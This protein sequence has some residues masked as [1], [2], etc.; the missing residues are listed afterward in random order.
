MH[1]LW[2]LMALHFHFS[3]SYAFLFT[4][5]F[6]RFLFFLVSFCYL[7]VHSPLQYFSFFP[8]FL[9]YNF[10]ISLFNLFLQYSLTSLP[11]VGLFFISV[12]FQNLYFIHVFNIYF[13]T[14]YFLSKLSTYPVSKLSLLEHKAPNCFPYVSLQPSMTLFFAINFN[15][16][17]VMFNDFFY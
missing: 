12:I 6:S 4:L 15:T 8:S 1:F 10:V 16:S 13:K 9:S 2:M 3:L 7:I 14:L 17:A 5:S 11:V